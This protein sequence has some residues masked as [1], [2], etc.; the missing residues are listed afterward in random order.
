MEKN[1]GVDM[2]DCKGYLQKPRALT[3]KQKRSE[4]KFKNLYLMVYTKCDIASY[5]R[6]HV[7]QKFGLELNK[8]LRGNHVSIVAETYDPH[9][10]DLIRDKLPKVLVFQYDPKV[11]SNGKHWWLRVNSND[12]VQVR[13]M[14]GLSDLPYFKFHLTIGHC[15]DKDLE[16]SEWAFRY[17]KSFY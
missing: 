11:L 14:L 4:T 3:K 6:W 12:F 10:F 7:K 15:K 1:I 17:S 2:F 9:K 5:Y 13:R 8:P 16:T